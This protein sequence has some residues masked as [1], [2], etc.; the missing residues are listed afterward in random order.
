MQSAMTEMPSALRQAVLIGDRARVHELISGGADVNEVGREGATPLMLASG[1][2]HLW[3]GKAFHADLAKARGEAYNP[4]DLEE[5]LCSDYSDEVRA[6]LVQALLIAKANVNARGNDGDM[7][8]LRAVDSDHVATVQLLLAAQA[9]VNAAD[10]I[11]G[12]SSLALCAQRGYGDIASALLAAKADVNI[13]TADSDTALMLSAKNGH[14]R[15]VRALLKAQ[16]DLSALSAAGKTAADTALRSGRP[17]IY[18]LLDPDGAK[19]KGAELRKEFNQAQLVHVLSTRYRRDKLHALG[20]GCC[21]PQ[22]AAAT[23][24]WA[25]ELDPLIGDPHEMS[26]H[27]LDRKSVV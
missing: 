11:R 9:E 4:I 25:L 22:A 13:R 5:Q 16:V 27:G 1:K 24:K 6:G 18:A 17:L 20:A 10:T 8:L 2:S 14:M 15:V 21:D 12:Y 23:V 3:V 7:A 19:A 26:L